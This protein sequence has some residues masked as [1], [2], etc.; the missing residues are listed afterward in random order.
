MDEQGFRKKLNPEQYRVM[1]EKGEERPYTGKYWD[2]EAKGTYVCAACNSV[3]FSSDAKFD[4]NTGWP[5]FK[6]PVDI[7]RLTLT[8]VMPAGKIQKEVSCKEC[9]SHL[10]YVVKDPAKEGRVQY[11]INSASLD[12]EEP[13]ELELEEESEKKEDE[14][15]K[16]KEAASQKRL[17]D[18]LKNILALLAV[19]GVAGAAGL[20][21]CKMTCGTA[22]VDSENIGSS[23]AV[24]GV[25]ELPSISPISSPIPSPQPTAEPSKGPSPTPS[26][27]QTL[28]PAD[29]V[30]TTPRAMT[31]SSSAALPNPPEESPPPTGMPV[32]TPSQGTGSSDGTL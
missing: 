14:E 17:Q 4:S 10:G 30:I 2:S 32:S 24:I 20:G 31:A 26:K 27:T 23:P 19:A 7:K 12:F 16:K 1:R 3:L 22:N 25:E 5:S 29:P 13:I 8:P 11:R 6:E 21:Y 28:N 9:G 15:K 18:I